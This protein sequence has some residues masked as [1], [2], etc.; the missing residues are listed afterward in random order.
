VTTDVELPLDARFDAAAVGV[1]DI[2]V[3]LGTLCTTQ[4]TTVSVGPYS[5]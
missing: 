3:P 5:L 4:P 2:E 1:P